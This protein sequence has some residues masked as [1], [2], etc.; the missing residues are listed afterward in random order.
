MEMEGANTQDPQK[1]CPEDFC[2]LMVSGQI[3]LGHE[4][5]PLE[6][7]RGMTILAKD[8]ATVGRV[9]AVVLITTGQPANHL[10]LSHLPEQADYRLVPVES[11]RQVRQDTIVLNLSSRQVKVLPRWRSDQPFFSKESQ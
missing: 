2:H 7:R 5:S 3:I 10:L 8:G 1:A 9:A 4:K 11:I 6:I